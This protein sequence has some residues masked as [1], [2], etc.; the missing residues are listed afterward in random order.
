[1]HGDGQRRHDLQQQE[2]QERH[3]KK[4]RKEKAWQRKRERQ[5][6]QRDTWVQVVEYPDH[7]STALSLT[8]KDDTAQTRGEPQG[9]ADDLKLV[10]PAEGQDAEAPLRGDLEMTSYGEETMVQQWGTG[11]QQ[12]W[13]ADAECQMDSDE[14]WSLGCTRVSDKEDRNLAGG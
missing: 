11:H 9:E 1:M 5:Q 7:W 6:I 4:Q 13:D 2:A 10:P 14:S 3:T 8:P 12:P